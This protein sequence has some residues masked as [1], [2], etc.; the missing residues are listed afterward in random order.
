MYIYNNIR[1]LQRAISGDNNFRIISRGKNNLPLINVMSTR[2]HNKSLYVKVLWR[3]QLSASNQL[4][5]CPTSLCESIFIRPEI[6][7]SRH[8]IINN[9][10]ADGSRAR[11]VSRGFVIAKISSGSASPY[12]SM[13]YVKTT[14]FYTLDKHAQPRYLP[15]KRALAISEWSKFRDH[16]LCDNGASLSL[17]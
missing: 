5:F 14:G 7:F 4:Y 15:R 9:G 10:A 6:A 8:I 1:R 2:S 13:F 11:F 12:R 16:T 17:R 3:Q